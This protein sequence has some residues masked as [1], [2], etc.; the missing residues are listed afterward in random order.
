MERSQEKFP[1]FTYAA[2]CDLWFKKQY[3]EET[4]A[5][6]CKQRDFLF[7]YFIIYAIKYANIN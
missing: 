5:V 6:N 4:T 3:T 1:S 2:L 7:H